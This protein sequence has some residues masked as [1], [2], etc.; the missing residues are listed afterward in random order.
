MSHKLAYSVQKSPHNL[1]ALK[2]FVAVLFVAIL[3]AEP[4]CA[5]DAVKE[6]DV[7]YAPAVPAGTAP[8]L[9]PPKARRRT[10]SLP[11]KAAKITLAD[12]IAVLENRFM[13]CELS[14]NNGPVISRLV[15]KFIS[16]NVLTGP[17]RLFLAHRGKN[18]ISNNTYQ[19]VKAFV[20]QEG[21]LA[22]IQILH[23]RWRS[24]TDPI[25]IG[26]RIT[27]VDSP[28]LTWQ[29][30]VTNT[31]ENPQIF[32]VTG[33]VLE[34][35][36]I[37]EQVSDDLYFFPQ[38]SGVCGGLDANLW[39]AYGGE[40]WMQV[41]NVFDPAVGGGVY[42]FTQDTTGYPEIL[43]LRKKSPGSGKP[44]D[45][46]DWPYQY[47]SPEA[48]FDGQTGTAMAFRHL[49]YALPKGAS[50]EL[51]GAVIGV[52]EG[53]WHDPL[54]RYSQWAHTWYRKPFPT[55][56]WYMDTYAYLCAH[57]YGLFYSMSKGWTNDNGATGYWDAK[58]KEYAYSRGMGVLEENSLMEWAM[59]WDFK[60]LVDPPT[61]EN[62]GKHG[63]PMFSGTNMGDYDYSS[64]MGGLPALREEISRIH[65][66]KGRFIL[67]TCPPAVWQGSRIGKAHGKDWAMMTDP[68]VYSHRW[69]PSDEGWYACLYAPGLRD[70]YSNLFAKKVKETGAD[71]VRLD[72]AAYMYPCHNV[73]H[74]HCDGTVR[75]TVSP[76][77]M[78]ELLNTCQKKVRT[79]NP[80]AVVTTEYAGSDFL[81]QFMDGYMIASIAFYHPPKD[82]PFAA[83]NQYRL[84]FTRF[85]F[86]EA[87]PV[88]LGMGQTHPAQDAVNMSLFNATPVGYSPVAAASGYD[89]LRE[90]GDAINSS[91][92]PEPMIDTLVDHVYANYFPGPAKKVWLI[93][94]RSGK[95][96][97]QPL[98]QTP[99]KKGAH[100]VEA[101]HD[102]PV[103]A[104]RTGELVQLSTAIENQ[105]VL[106]I[107]ELPEML[108]ASITA[109]VLN[110]QLLQ[111]KGLSDTV[112]VAFGEDAAGKRRTLN[113]TDGKA[114]LP[115]PASAGDSKV[116]VRAMKGYHVA[117]E[118]VLVP[119]LSRDK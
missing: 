66:K 8:A 6:K 4:L 75:S 63:I 52:H 113:L 102:T 86:P 27:L 82:N 46:G 100:Y 80:D 10:E 54:K 33:P 61:M 76:K 91:M 41:M 104:I 73:A 11:G 93:Y 68:G 51:P 19:L 36:R 65:E 56:S 21:R 18:L 83:L 77:A 70:V 50:A 116:V 58:K 1:I 35:I 34:N 107:V 85:Y 12:G 81:T 98:I 47:Q 9:L 32:G 53:D 109:G 99:F 103:N 119:S 69:L 55:P 29:A 24:T 118:V 44:L 7:A 5:Q 88:I 49:E 48:L 97:N 31:A 17:S 16:Q 39:A 15:N 57:S 72:V 94:N 105:Q 95:R 115:L 92:M 60:Y 64:A 59:W 25:E 23:A 62:Y 111:A 87:K 79:V 90:N 89:A 108:K 13:R 117:D 3:W 71:G 14:L 26:M 67:Y 84:I 42:T 78:A 74:E 28:E 101:F 40:A 43:I 37:G 2:M 96:L 106:C 30:T 110:V 20:V 22:E 112:Q 38:Q 45:Y 114:Q